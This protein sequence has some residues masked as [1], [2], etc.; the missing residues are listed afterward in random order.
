MDRKEA[1]PVTLRGILTGNAAR[2]CEATSIHGFA[3]WVAAP[4]LPEKFFWVVVTIA[5][6]V[7]ASLIVNEAVVNW[8]EQPGTTGIAT[9]SKAQIKPSLYTNICSIVN[10]LTF[11]Y[12]VGADGEFSRSDIL[13]PRRL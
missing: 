2:Y 12:T 4:R 11:L 13:Q 1:S 7:C 9:F 5:G 8:M 3:Y 6:F 10:C